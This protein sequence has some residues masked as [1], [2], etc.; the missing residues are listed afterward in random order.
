[1]ADIVELF[2]KLVNIVIL[3]L[4]ATIVYA[5][6]PTLNTILGIFSRL[7]GGRTT[8]V[9][10]LPERLEQPRYTE[11]QVE[12]GKRVASEVVKVM[13]MIPDGMIEQGGVNGIVFWVERSGRTYTVEIVY[14]EEWSGDFILRVGEQV[15][16]HIEESGKYDVRRVRY[17]SNKQVL[18]VTRL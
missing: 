16:L 9:D 12:I 17:A 10:S 4:I 8:T 5:V 14:P 3:A 2:N 7:V 1:M 18:E 15:K 11:E 13:D 6:V